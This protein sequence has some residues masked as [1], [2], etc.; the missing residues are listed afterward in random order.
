MSL[1]R[2]A[3]SGFLWTS[4]FGMLSRVVTIGSTFALTR[5]L[6][7]E[8][9]GEVNLASVLVLTLGAATS[10]GVMQ[11][12]TAHPREGSDML[13]HGHLMIVSTGVLC[14]LVSWLVAEPVGRML[15]VP[16]LVAFVPGLAL[17]YV[18]ERLGWMPRSILLRELRFRTFG[19]RVAV[20]EFTFATVAV[21]LAWGGL[22]G[23]AIVWA[24]LARS[25]TSLLF[26][27]VT[28]R[29]RDY[30]TPYRLLGAQ[31]RKMLRFGLPITVANFFGMGAT[32]WDNS[33]MGYRFGE[34]TVGIYNQGYRLA[35]L[36]SSTFGDQIN[37]VLVPTF[38][39]LESVA[40]RKRAFLRAAS[41]M[42]LL[43]FPAAFGI[44][45]VSTTLVEAFYPPAYQDVG[46]FLMVL[47]ATNFTR[48]LGN[49][50]GAFLQVVHRTAA[51]A[52]IDFLLLVT[53]LGLMALLAPLGPLA[54]SA[55]VGIAFTIAVLLT[56]RVLRHEDLSLLEIAKAC[57]PPLLACVPLVL[58]VGA[59]SW[60]MRGAIGSPVLRLAVEVLVGGACYVAASFIVGRKIALDFI[61]LALG[62][63]RRRRA[64]AIPD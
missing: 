29:A 21:A 54:S 10:L 35:D 23:M 55:G 44:S 7:P 11:Y 36:P 60:A 15:G 45:V 64:R 1:A 37:D 30:L 40:D 25:T 5:F 47:A 58:G 62:T 38:G 20:G 26:L 63:L 52:V 12:A 59:A 46:P 42:S 18:I 48:A 16:G 61:D 53:V 17:A 39:K 4:I 24:S 51:F 34:A 56:L 14:G 28:T 6:A 32:N 43:V 9:Y 22:G 27:L 19:L 31:F 3:A 41:L 50:A 33:F 57:A 8:V 13:F 49:L 2:I